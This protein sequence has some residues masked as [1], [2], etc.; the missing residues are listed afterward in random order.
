MNYLTVSELANILGVTPQG[1]NKYMRDKGLQSQAVK[2]GNKF[3]I[4]ETLAE[5]IRNHFKPNE[6]DLL[7][8]FFQ[9]ET[10]TETAETNTETT[11]TE[12]ETNG[13]KESAGQA[14]ILAAKVEQLEI[15]LKE[16]DSEIEFL[17]NELKDSREI[18]KQL[19]TQNTVYA[20]KY[21]VESSQENEQNSIIDVETEKE[22]SEIEI[23][24]IPI[25]E[26][27]QPQNDIWNKLERLTFGQRIKFA[28]TGRID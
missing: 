20:T 17:R 13:N 4:N 16:K 23:A 15:R 5:T 7:K 18:Q 9:S 28:F 21:L 26:T 24:E 27:E 22:E 14:A 11:E 12:T 6:R 1:I 19:A 8:S 2:N 3:L 10:E 25:E